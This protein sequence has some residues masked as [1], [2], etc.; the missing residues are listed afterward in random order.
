MAEEV[1]QGTPEWF[2]QRL[3]RATGSNFDACLAQGKGNAEASTRAQ[4]RVRLA[5]ERLTGKVMESGFKSA[6]MDQG[7]EREPFARMAYEIATGQIVKE[8][9]FV[10]HKKL[11]AGV[12]PDGEVGDDGMVEFKCPS[13]AVHWDYLHLVNTPPAAYKA[14]V[15][16]QMWVTGRKWV[17][18]CTFNPDFPEPL[19]LHIV[20]VHRD[21]EII[22]NMEAGITKFLVDVDTTYREMKMLAEARARLL[23]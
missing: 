7:T 5:V 21:E 15:Y 1:I 14:Q 10:Q 19:Q 3:G 6:A 23:V 18:F 4:Y 8:V 22:R 12:S 16:G 13:P 20:R 9:S 2:Q 17:D 11:M